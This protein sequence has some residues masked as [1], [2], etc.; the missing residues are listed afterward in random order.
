[1]SYFEIGALLALKEK[2]QQVDRIR[3]LMGDEV[4]KRTNKAFAEGL[5]KIADRLDASLESEK[6]RND[7]LAGVPAI[8]EAL[9][10]GKIDCRV[11]RKDKFHAKAYITHA[12][13]KVIGSFGLVGSSNLTYPGLADNVELN[14]QIRG[15][16]VKLLQEWYERHWVDAQD[17]TPDILRVVDRQVHPYKPFE[18]WFKG[19]HE[20][21][22]GTMLSPDHWDESMSVMFR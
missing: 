2:W 21:L 11:Y 16:D 19:L 18:V 15:N 3:I 5:R 9:R 10:S 14:V 6:V 12:R 13:N 17:V 8:V 22:R 20:L 7:F 1:T 4:S